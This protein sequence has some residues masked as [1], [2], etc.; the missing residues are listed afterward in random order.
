MTK[1]LVIDDEEYMGW[2]IR[3]AFSKSDAE[4]VTALTGSEGIKLI[5]SE[6]PDLIML[7]LRLPDYDGLDILK[8]IKDKGLDTPV[9]IITAHGSID[10]AITSMKA[11]AFDYITKPFDVDELIFTAEKAIEMGRLKNEVTFLRSQALKVGIRTIVESKNP[12][13][14]QIYN[15]LPQIASSQATV[16]ITGESGTGKEVIGREI[17]RLSSR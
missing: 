17:H 6:Y 14:R 1:I 15:I 10:T 3:K 13:M 4:I 11:G 8:E 2:I 12:I 16:L 9:I 5:D 7:D